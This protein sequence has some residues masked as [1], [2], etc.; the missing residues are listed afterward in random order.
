M[1]V[2]PKRE[3][4]IALEVGTKV[5]FSIGEDV[6]TDVVTFVGDGIIEGEKYD[7]T[8]VRFRVVSA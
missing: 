5:E 4:P 3:N 2:N 8:H 1:Q 7:L 6:F